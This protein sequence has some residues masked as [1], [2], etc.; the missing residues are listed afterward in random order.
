[1][2]ELLLAGFVKTACIG[3]QCY[4]L[5]KNIF[6]GQFLKIMFST[7]FLPN[8]F[9]W[10]SRDFFKN[11]WRKKRSRRRRS[12]KKRK[13]VN[14][15]LDFEQNVFHWCCQGCFHKRLE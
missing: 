1:M 10:Y 6:F 7:E 11:D 3:V 4:I 13:Y 5:N 8:V 14:V 12:G 2:S 15:F 9:S